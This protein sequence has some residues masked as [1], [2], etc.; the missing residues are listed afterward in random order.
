MAKTTNATSA[1]RTKIE[2][3]LTAAINTALSLGI[4]PPPEDLDISSIHVGI[5]QSQISEREIDELFVTG[6]VTSII[7]PDAV[8]SAEK[9]D[10]TVLYTQGKDTIGTGNWDYYSDILAP[11]HLLSGALP[12]QHKWS[13]AGGNVGDE[14]Y[15]TD[16]DMTFIM[17]V[18]KPV[19]GA[20]SEKIKIT[21]SI[22]T[23]AVGAPAII[24]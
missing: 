7:T 20:T 22:F 4:D 21:Y 14:Q 1:R 23:P 13:P 12:L 17:S 8:V 10:I 11:L 16:P 3:A 6:D 24:T 19:G 9:Y 5:E 2:V 15:V 18:P